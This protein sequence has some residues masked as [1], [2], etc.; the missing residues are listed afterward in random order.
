MLA[1]VDGGGTRRGRWPEVA[2]EG[3]RHDRGVYAQLHRRRRSFT[4]REY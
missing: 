3:P 2:T 4:E 1:S